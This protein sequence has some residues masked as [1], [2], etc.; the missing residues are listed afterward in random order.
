MTT[1]YDAQQGV[2]ISIAI[3]SAIFAAIGVQIPL[4]PR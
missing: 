3:G 4:K 1:V 2:G